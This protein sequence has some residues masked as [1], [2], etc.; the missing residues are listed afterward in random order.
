MLYAT[1][2]TQLSVFQ[3]LKGKLPSF[4]QSQNL[5]ISA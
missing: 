5:T 1:F 3:Q 2:M 4:Q